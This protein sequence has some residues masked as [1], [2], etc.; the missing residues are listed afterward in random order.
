M[1]KDQAVNYLNTVGLFSNWYRNAAIKTLVNIP[2]IESTLIL[3]KALFVEHPNI[4]VIVESLKSLSLDQDA[5]RIQ[6]LWQLWATSPNT[7]LA[8]ILITLGWPAQCTMS[9]QL[10]KKLLLLV[11]PTSDSINTQVVEACVYNLPKNNEIVNDTLYTAWIASQSVKLEEFITVSKCQPGDPTLEAL[12][13]LVTGQLSRYDALN[14]QDGELLTHAIRLANP[15]FLER[16]AQT[17][18]ASSKPKLQSFYR[19]ALAYIKLD[20]AQR[21]RYIMLA[22]DEEGLFEQIPKLRLIEVLELCER[23]IKHPNWPTKFNQKVTLKNILSIYQTL[24]IP[25]QSPELTV[26]DGMVDIFN[27]WDNGLG[28]P[29]KN[30]LDNPLA[31]ARNTYIENLQDKSPTTSKQLS[32]HWLE[33]LV[34]YIVDINKLSTAQNDSVDIIAACANDAALLQTS[35][36]GTPNDYV[37]HVELLEKTQSKATDNTFS[38]G[39]LSIL[40]V[41]QKIFI[42]TEITVETVKEPTE[43]NAIELEDYTPVGTNFGSGPRD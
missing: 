28:I 25:R 39:L 30:Y 32:K 29:N 15:N 4:S 9:L 22:G 31:C 10:A 13:A 37:Q 19:N 26:P 2:E 24:K 21:L 42:G 43:S 23:W 27:Y 34:A 33:R 5:D 41:L 8:S 38:L 16:I 3:A 40:C 12:H 18:N 11:N 20:N 35:I 6:A 36:S 7:H 1:T 14:D 17:I